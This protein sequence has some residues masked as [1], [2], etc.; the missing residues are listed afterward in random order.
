MDSRRFVVPIVSQKCNV[1]MRWREEGRKE[2][3][4]EGR[5]KLA[6]FA[7]QCN[8]PHVGGWEG[9]GREG[10]ISGEL[11]HYLVCVV[12]A[13]AVGA[14]S[15]SAIDFASICPLTPRPEALTLLHKMLLFLQVDATARR[16]LAS[17]PRKQPI[18]TPELDGDRA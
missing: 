15:N 9:R 18:F 17:A 10:N 1:I 2:G 14:A 13:D 8:P 4:K 16:S 7:K 3:G 5:R 12:D 6:K 11:L